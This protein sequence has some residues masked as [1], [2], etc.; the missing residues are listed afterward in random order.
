MESEP[1][2]RGKREKTVQVKGGRKKEIERE[3]DQSQK[4][5]GRE[6]KLFK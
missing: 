6:R 5:G 1:K 4:E 2:R 3:W